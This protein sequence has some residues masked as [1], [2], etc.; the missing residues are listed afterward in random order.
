CVAL[1]PC[2]RGVRMSPHR[3]MAMVASRTVASE[4]SAQSP[5]LSTDRGHFVHREMK[6]TVELRGQF[7]LTSGAGDP[8]ITRCSRSSSGRGALRDAARLLDHLAEARDVS[9]GL[10]VDAERLLHLA[11]TVVHGGM[12][13]PAEG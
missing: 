7:L 3:A 5:Q 8:W 4:R 1:A 11:P 2:V 10:R 6:T 9:A 13:A 12:V